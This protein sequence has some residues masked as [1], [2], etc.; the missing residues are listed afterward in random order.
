M[1]KNLIIAFSAIVLAGGVFVV[2]KVL[3]AN[4]D[5]VLSK[6]VDV[7]S[8]SETITVG[9]ICAYEPEKTCDWYYPDGSWDILDDLIRP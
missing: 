8:A 4:Q 2:G 9:Q 1:K 5:T 3:T 7:L 6:N